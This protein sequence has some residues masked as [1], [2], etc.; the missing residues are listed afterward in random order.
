MAENGG[1]DPTLPEGWVGISGLREAVRRVPLAHA[2]VRANYIAFPL[3]LWQDLGSPA[4]MSFYFYRYDTFLMPEDDY[5]VN[6][7]LHRCWINFMPNSCLRSLWTTGTFPDV[8][9]RTLNG[10]AGVLIK[11]IN[12]TLIDVAAFEH[13]RNERRKKYNK[14]PIS[15]VY[16]P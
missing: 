14:R 3:H 10:I 6:H 9:I 12:R 13:R 15:D 5:I 8:S 7:N 11:N 2:V 4:R 1:M 16:E